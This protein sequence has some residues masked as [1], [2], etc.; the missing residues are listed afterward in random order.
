M[1]LVFQIFGNGRK[2][3]PMIYGVSVQ[4]SLCRPKTKQGD[5]VVKF[6][7]IILSAYLRSLNSWHTV[8]TGRHHVSPVR[9]AG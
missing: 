8:P 3:S 9:R 6:E 7:G 2:S 4:V 5:P 1:G